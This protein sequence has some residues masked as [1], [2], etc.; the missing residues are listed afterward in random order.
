MEKLLFS[1]SSVSRAKRAVI[2]N[3]QTCIAKL[4]PSAKLKV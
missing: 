2:I 4:G 3:S 1:A